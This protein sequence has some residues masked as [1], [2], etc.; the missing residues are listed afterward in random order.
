MFRERIAGVWTPVWGGRGGWVWL[1][2]G[3]GSYD[4]AGRMQWAVVRGPH[5][6]LECGKAFADV[7]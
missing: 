4:P 5:E 3:S 2:S 1:W 7:S 6:P